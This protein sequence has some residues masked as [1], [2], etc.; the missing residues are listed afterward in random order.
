MEEAPDVM[1][2]VSTSMGTVTQSGSMRDKMVW[3]K[4][5]AI[6]PADWELFLILPPDHDVAL[7]RALVL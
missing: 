5:R 3:R 7:E 6:S 1:D 2:N 4:S